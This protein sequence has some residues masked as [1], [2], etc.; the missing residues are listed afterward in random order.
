MEQRVKFFAKLRH[1]VGHLEKDTAHLQ[2]ITE[3]QN[4]DDTSEGA[5]LATL[6]ELQS[7]VRGFKSQI[8]QELVKSKDEREEGVN[9][10]Q[11]WSEKRQQVKEALDLLSSHLEQYGYK[12]R[13]PTQKPP[14]A[15]SECGES[16][17]QSE[18]GEEEEEE[19]EQETGEED[20]DAEEEDEDEHPE[21]HKDLDQLTPERLA[22]SLFSVMCTPK[23]TDFG[24]SELHLQNMLKNY[25]V[26]QDPTPMAPKGL[27]SPLSAPVQP[28]VPK[29]PKCFLKLDED[30]PT[31]Q[32]EDF[33]I[34]EYTMRLNN[35][36]TMDLLR[37]PPK[38]SSKQS[39]GP[40]ETIPQL[41][42]SSLVFSEYM[43]TPVTPEIR[44]PGFRIMKKAPPH[45]PAQSCH[46]N[47]DSPPSQSNDLISPELPT[48]ETPYVR[49][50]LSVQKD[51]KSDEPASQKPGLSSA[52]ERAPALNGPRSSTSEDIPEMPVKPCDAELQRTPEMPS[53]QSILGRTLQSIN[54]EA[55]SLSIVG[56]AGEPAP[57]PK[58]PPAPALDL[59]EN[60]T[61]EW[62]LSSPRVRREFESEPRTP[63]M[64]DMSSITQDIFK[65]VSQCNTEMKS[66]AI[67]PPLKAGLQATAT[68]KENKPA[69]QLQSLALVTEKEFLGLA[70]YLRKI[71]LGRL[72]EAI[73][74]IN[75]A[76]HQRQNGSYSDPMQFLMD[77]LRSITGIGVKAPMFLLCLTQLKRVE[78]IQGA[79][80]NAMYKLL[81]TNT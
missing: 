43:D 19:L 50:L 64:P 77:E 46:N 34:S 28:P 44:T 5:C 58:E 59:Q 73:Q 13:Q 8:Q 7:D 32:L 16:E 1:L 31:P 42:P 76:L 65:L 29:T 6:H 9:F 10:I 48:F 25:G 4:H 26:A 39:S 37:K 41:A 24:L 21:Q 74:E 71:P 12:P 2:E 17:S 68:G 22:P 57:G 62:N 75:T 11:T 78:H 15:G 80:N 70:S 45:T 30:A 49:K 63:E 20:Q 35:D 69:I 14:V 3:S 81:P 52:F 54:V 67:Q 56:M 51:I 66:A 27:L 47:P 38:A 60:Y 18:A 61:Q 36:F 53:L 23:L 33:G 72:N 55:R 79:G 40:V